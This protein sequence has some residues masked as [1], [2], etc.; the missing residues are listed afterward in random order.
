MIEI[1]ERTCGGKVTYSDSNY[2]S[3]GEYQTNPESGKVVVLNMSINKQDGAYVGNIGSYMDG[4][5]LRL[6][7]NGIALEELATVFTSISNCITEIEAN[8]SKR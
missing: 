1:N 4:T 8:E 6:N 7:L 2:T 5:T 3:V